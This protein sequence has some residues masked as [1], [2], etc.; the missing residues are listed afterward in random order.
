M[1]ETDEDALAEVYNHGLELEKKG[2]H[3][4][5]EREYRKLLEMD[6]SDPG[7]VSIR[8]AAMGRMAAPS[9]MPDAYVATLFDQH[10][11]VFDDILVDQLGYCVPLL[12][13]E[14]IRKLGLGP[15]ETLLDLGCG[16]GLTGIAFSDCAARMTGV[17]LSERI[18]ELAYDREVYEDLYIGEAVEFLQ[19]FEED[20]GTRPM[21]DFIA[22]TDVFPYLG[23]VR[24]I[25]SAAADRLPKGRLFAF[26]TETLPD[27]AFADSCFAVGP[28]NRFAHHLPHLLSELEHAGFQT[29]SRED[30]TVRLEDGAPVP[31]HMIVSKKRD[32]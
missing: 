31:G 4:G 9:K 8:L 3:D 12:L 28:K 2:D 7:G 5:A 6:P 13:R 10:A 1:N 20:D 29:L 19:E 18:V 11:D 14:R 16:T 21:Y 32:Q 15:F 30:I 27:P 22:A 26:S 25:I 24:P 17:D 23:E